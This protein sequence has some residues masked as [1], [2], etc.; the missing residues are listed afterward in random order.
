MT[1]GSSYQYNV[2]AELY[3]FDTDTWKT[4]KDYPYAKGEGLYGYAMLFFQETK[5]YFVIGGATGKNGKDRV[6]HI[7][8]FTNGDWSL[9]GKLNSER[10]VSFFVCF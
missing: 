1:V 5:S 6:P 10:N 7:A 8:K 2:K 9:V 4:V 3:S